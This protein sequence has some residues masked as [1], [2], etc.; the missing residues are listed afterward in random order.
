MFGVAEARERAEVFRELTAMVHAGVSIGES[1]T[2]VAAGMRPSHLRGGLL[3]AGYDVSGGHAIS[4]SFEQHPH[5][6]SA[7]ELA[8]LRVGEQAGRLEMALR[9]IADYHERDFKLRSIL[10]RELTYPIILLCAIILIPLAGRMVVAWITAGLGAALTIGASTLLGYA[11]FLGIPAIIIYLIIR[12]ARQSGGGRLWLDQAKLSIPL[13]GP[14]ARKVALARFCRALAA[15]YSAGVLMGSSLRLAGEA[16]GNEVIA[17]KIEGVARA[18]EAGGGLSDALRKTA[19]MP[20]TVLQMLA[21]GERTG[22]VDAMADHVANH[23]E[24]EAQTAVSAMAVA[25]MPIAVV[26]A[27]IIVAVMAISF[28]G[29]LYA[30]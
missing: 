26:I 4:E 11:I 13:I 15:L 8:M 27:G 10:Q 18:V 22:E 2:T 20:G 30:F 19:L 1:L 17:R 29:G 7:L 12:N 3:R 5:V 16:S 6:F 14:V 25:I 21:T 24:M 9:A 23:L 28:Y